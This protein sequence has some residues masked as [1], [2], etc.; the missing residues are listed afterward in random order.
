[1]QHIE[2]MSFR[3]FIRTNVTLIGGVYPAVYAIE[4][5]LLTRAAAIA[6]YFA[7]YRFTRLKVTLMPP[8]VSSDLGLAGIG[9]VTDIRH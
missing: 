5:A 8:Y 7:L 6:Q 3:E 9:L 4:P 1:M 2:K